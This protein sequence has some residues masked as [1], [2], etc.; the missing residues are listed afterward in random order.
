MAA[1]IGYVHQDG[2]LL[3]GSLRDNMVLGVPDPGDERILEIAKTFGAYDLIIKPAQLGL[4][5]PVTESGAGLSGGQKQLV[6]I[7][8]A[9]L[10]DPAFF[11]LDEPT[12]SLDQQ[13][14]MLVMSGLADL[15]RQDP[16]KSLVFVTHKPKLLDL[17][18]RIIV[19]GNGRIVLDGPRDEIIKR[20]ATP[21]RPKGQV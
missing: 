6:Q 18:D 17:V 14:E 5:L 20:L 12:A 13:A 1:N 8:R 19:M 15:L 9:V 3:S 16:E 10:K 7:V 4:D 11:M 2:R 21:A